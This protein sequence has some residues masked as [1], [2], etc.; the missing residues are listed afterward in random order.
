MKCGV[1]SAEC[2]VRGVASSPAPCALRDSQGRN[3]VSACLDGSLPLTPTLSPGRGGSVVCASAERRRAGLRSFTLLEVMIAMAIFFMA[4]FAILSL[5]AQNLQ[6]A[7]NLRCSEVDFSTVA[8]EL[9]LTNR[10]QEGSYSGDFGDFYPGA[11][12]MAD[13]Y[14]YATGGLYQVD[15]TVLWPRNKS[16]SAEHTSILLYRPESAVR[17]GALPRLR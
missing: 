6:I 10:L 9:A 12:W 3:A 8:A 2:G 11:E 14:L 15:I 7:R 16:V 5:V 13:V 1:R 4:I 17:A